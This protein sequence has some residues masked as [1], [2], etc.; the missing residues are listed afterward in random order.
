MTCEPYH[1]TLPAFRSWSST[2]FKVDYPFQ[3]IS[4]PWEDR[5]DDLVSRLTLEE[6]QAQ[7][8]MGGGPPRGGP[9]PAIP[10]FGIGPYQWW[11]NCGRGDAG[12]PGNATAF[13]QGIGLGASFRY[14]L[15]LVE[16]SVRSL[17]LP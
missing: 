5:V 9:A 4:L 16:G 14:W 7:L 8:S 6:V 12:A 1:H 13:P 17:L 2:P 3:N 15:F 11:S 10:R